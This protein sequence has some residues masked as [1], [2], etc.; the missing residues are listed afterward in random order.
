MPY[1]LIQHEVTKYEVFE[2]VYKDD[3]EFRRRSG[4]KKGKLFRDLADPNSL[5]VILEFDSADEANKFANSYEL[6]E[7][8]E[9]AGSAPAR[10]IVLEEILD[11]DA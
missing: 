10:A 2:A 7:A 8:V 11:T 9:W 1:V 5:V 6:K 3:Q 4:S